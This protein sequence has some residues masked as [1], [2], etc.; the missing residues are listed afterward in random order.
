MLKPIVQPCCKLIIPNSQLKMDFDRFAENYEH[1]VQE[2]TRFAR[3]PHEFFLEVKVGHLLD[4]LK[5]SFENF[6]ELRV[7]DVGLRRRFD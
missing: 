2:S 6:S 7:L 3:L 5:R 1:D 4:K